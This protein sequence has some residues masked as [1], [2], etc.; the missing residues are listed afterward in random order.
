MLREYNLL[1][2]CQAWINTVLS[3][4]S[5][6]NNTGRRTA[7]GAQIDQQMMMCAVENTGVDPRVSC[8][9]VAS[10]T[11]AATAHLARIPR[12]LAAGR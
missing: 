8:S 5:V 2:C 7:S 12:Q 4:C 1:I 6:H 11:S 10:R 3:G 9:P